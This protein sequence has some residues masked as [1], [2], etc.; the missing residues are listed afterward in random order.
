MQLPVKTRLSPCCA[1]YASH[2][3]PTMTFAADFWPQLKNIALNISKSE[4]DQFYKSMMETLV[5]LETTNVSHA[6]PCLRPLVRMCGPL[7][8]MCG[9]RPPLQNIDVVVGKHLAA[10]ITYYTSRPG[11]IVVKGVQV[12]F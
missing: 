7:V 10:V 2:T 12:S 5:V 1:L 11:R 8:R 3:M 4:R 9:P 6:K